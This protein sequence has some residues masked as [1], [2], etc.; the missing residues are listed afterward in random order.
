MKGE[1]E[2]QR[3]VDAERRERQAP[4]ETVPALCRRRGV[5]DPDPFQPKHKR[6]N[7]PLLYTTFP[8]IQLPSQLFEAMNTIIQAQL[9]RV[10]ASLNILIESIAS[11]NPSIPA[12]NALLAADDDL[13]RGLK[14]RMKTTTL[15]HN[16]FRYRIM[17]THGTI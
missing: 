10:E 16:R 3:T 11:Y 12:A 2:E 8:I 7:K 17:S 13:N 14:Q 5:P 6:L 1:E 9:E 4:P 15:D